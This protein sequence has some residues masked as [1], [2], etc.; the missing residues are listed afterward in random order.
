MVRSDLKGRGLGRMLLDRVIRFAGTQQLRALH[1]DI[2]YENWIMLELAQRAGFKFVGSGGP[3]V[4]MRLELGPRATVI[5]PL[6]STPGRI[7][8]HHH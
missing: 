8:F 1:A 4:T 7:A 3:M 2:L 6:V 5:S